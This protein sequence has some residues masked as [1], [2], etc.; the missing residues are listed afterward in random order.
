LSKPKLVFNENLG[1]LVRR[2]GHISLSSTFDKLSESKKR[3][4]NIM[5]YFEMYNSFRNANKLTLEIRQFFNNFFF[6]CLQRMEVD[7]KVYLKLFL[8]GV[9]NNWFPSF[10][11]AL[12]IFLKRYF[13]ANNKSSNL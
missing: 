13:L 4:I 7:K 5:A 6:K 1:A 10:I 8:L 12:K 9:I 3:L 11:L 2:D